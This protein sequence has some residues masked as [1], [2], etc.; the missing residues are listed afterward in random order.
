MDLSKADDCL[1]HDFLLAKLS[2]YV[3]NESAIT[4]I[5]NYLSNR[6]QRVKSGS[7]FSSYLEILGIP[8]GSML[9]PILCNLFIK[10]L[11]FFV[12]ETTLPMIQQYSCPPNFDEATL[13]LSNDTHLILN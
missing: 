6:Y 13:K 11:I 8:Q 1:P 12:Q 3:F 5:V 9:G 2:A 10:H 7:T 4:L